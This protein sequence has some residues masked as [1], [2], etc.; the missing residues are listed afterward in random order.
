VHNAQNRAVN[1]IFATF[2]IP[3]NIFLVLS[4]RFT[5]ISKRNVVCG[6]DK[7]DENVDL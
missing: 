1:I 7:V 4:E 5:S 3:F 6:F 2:F